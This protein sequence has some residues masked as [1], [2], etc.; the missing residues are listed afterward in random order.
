MAQ[1]KTSS[2]ARFKTAEYEGSVGVLTKDKTTH[3]Q[4]EVNV[5]SLKLKTYWHL[6]TAPYRT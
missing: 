3:S 1:V 4:Y 2:I 5:W 6:A